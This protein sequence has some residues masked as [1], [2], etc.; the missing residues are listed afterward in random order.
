MS[1]LPSLNYQ[2]VVKR[3]RALGFVFD[4]SAKGSHEVWYN[5]ITKRRTTIPHHPGDIPRGTLRAIIAQTGVSVEEFL[6]R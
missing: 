1:R 2:A 6:Q 4:R 3:L 5:P